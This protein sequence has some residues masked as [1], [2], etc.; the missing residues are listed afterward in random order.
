MGKGKT[1]PYTSFEA[2]NISAAE[3]KLGHPHEESSG[4]ADLAFFP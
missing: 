3:R 4:Q 2:G 1:I